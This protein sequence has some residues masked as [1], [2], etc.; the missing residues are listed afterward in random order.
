MG[1]P[2]K[3]NEREKK[4][5]KITVNTKAQLDELDKGSALTWEGLKTSDESLTEMFDWIKKYSPV[6]NETAYIV[7]GWVMNAAYGLT[8]DNAYPDDVHLVSVRLEDIE[9]VE[10]I[11]LPR[12]QAGGRWF[13]DIVANNAR[14]ENEKRN[15]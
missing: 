9:N 11:T 8:G 15:G 5:T 7:S 2:R 13:D 12:F 14:R 3:R 4:M 1:A 10:A 6:K